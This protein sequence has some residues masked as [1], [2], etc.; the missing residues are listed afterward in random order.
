MLNKEKKALI[1]KKIEEC[2]PQKRKPK[3]SNEYFLDR[4]L[5]ILKDVQT[6]RSFKRIYPTEKPGH[7]TTILKK[8]HKWSNLGIFVENNS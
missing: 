5:L 2:C 4:I 8:F 7:Y 3:Y 6:W 1:L